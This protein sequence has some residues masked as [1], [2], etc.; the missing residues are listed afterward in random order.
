MEP[1]LVHELVWYMDL[2]INF[3]NYIWMSKLISN[4]SP[5]F[6]KSSTPNFSQK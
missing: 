3:I 1:L 4:S 5:S 2:Y 6:E